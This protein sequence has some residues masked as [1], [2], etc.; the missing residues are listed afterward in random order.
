M[1]CFTVSAWLPERTEFD[2][3][4]FAMNHSLHR[5]LVAW[6]VFASAC[7]SLAQ[8][9]T[10]PNHAQVKALKVTIL[11][12]MLADEGIG[13]WGFAALVES[14]GHR[15]LVDTGAR[16]ETVLSNARELKVDLS[17]VEEVILTH[18]HDDHVG[19]LLTLRREFMKRNPKA[20]SVAH[21]GKGIFYSRPGNDGKEGNPMI[22]LRG[23]YESTG[24]KFAEHDRPVELFPG[25]WLTG[26]VPRTYPERNWSVKG[27]V[28]TPEGLVEDTIP[29][30]QSLILNTTK[31]LVMVTGCGHAGVIN[32]LTF[33]EKEFPGTPVY[34]VIGGLHLFPATDQQIDWTADKL[35]GFG[36]SYLVGAHCTGIESVYRIRQDLGLPRQSAVVGAV[37][38]TFVLDEGI[39]PGRIVQ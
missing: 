33:A 27:K 19:G 21:V 15:I 25:A 4:K 24:G 7:F 38:A 8:S 29:E 28:K 22:T 39:H 20:L 18:N 6:L 16:P 34:A 32:I 1:L 17:D 31:G 2:P 13:E 11:S 30:D 35:K 14:D 3:G 37:G 36:L 26:P 9:P 12:T 10:P 5:C 23:D